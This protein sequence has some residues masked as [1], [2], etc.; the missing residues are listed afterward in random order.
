[1]KRLYCLAALLLGQGHLIAAGLVLP[2]WPSGTIANASSVAAT[3]TDNGV[4][5]TYFASNAI[6]GNLNTFWNDNTPG[7]YP[8]ILTITSPS[9]IILNGVT[10]VS[11]PDGVPIDFS[12]DTWDGSD[13]NEAA[14]VT[15]NNG[16]VV[17]LP[18]SN[19]I[20]TTKVRLTV[21]QDQYVS[22]GEYTRVTVLWPGVIPPEDYA[23]TTTL[24]STTSTTATSTATGAPTA[25]TTSATATATTASAPNQ[26]SGSDGSSSDSSTGLSTGAKAGIGVAVP[27]VV[28]ILGLGI[29]WFWW[30][31]K[32]R[33][34]A[35][36]AAAVPPSG[37]AAMGYYKPEVRRAPTEVAGN[38]LSEADDTSVSPPR[39]GTNQPTVLPIYELNGDHAAITHYPPARPAPG[40]FNR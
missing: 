6:N 2:P 23:A 5:R 38:A 39:G 7:E 16:T 1:M 29:F 19:N 15:G 26:A 35:A 13:W 28:I 9:Y 14:T 24:V 11:N 4:L 32:Q 33:K 31:S 36:A 17:R 25:T 27:L 34:A 22:K 30:K 18:F 21:T 3:N 20:T 8:D 37:N 40:G 12:I 10:L